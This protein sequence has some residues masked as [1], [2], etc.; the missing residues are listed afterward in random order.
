M[1]TC[2]TYLFFLTDENLLGAV[3]R[4]GERPGALHTTPCGAP[5][6]AD[7]VRRSLDSV[8]FVCYPPIT[9]KVVILDLPTVKITAEPMCEITVEHAYPGP[10]KHPEP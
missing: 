9:A 3:V 10:C 4:A 6:T 5:I 7:E 2:A 1:R 8:A